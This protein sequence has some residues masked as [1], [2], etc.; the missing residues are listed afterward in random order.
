[1]HNLRPGK[2]DKLGIGYEALSAINPKLIY[3]YLPGY[4]SRGP[5]S[6]LKSFAP[7][8]SGWVGLLYEGGGEGNPPTRSVLGNEDY[9]NGFLG[10]VAVLMAVENRYRTG[11]GDYVECPQLHSSLFTTSEHFLDANKQVVYGLRMDG[12]QTGFN[13][14]DC[15][16][17]TSDGWICVCCR[18]D[19]RFAALAKGIGRED[20]LG[21][22]RF[23]TDRDRLAN[24]KVLREILTT[25]FA[26]LTSAEA[27]AQLDR[28][29]A[30]AEIVCETSWVQEALWQ[31]WAAKTDRVFE[32]KDSMYGH[33]REFG[34]F[35]RLS[36]TPGVR[37]GPAPR[38]GH[39]TREIL[40]EI[41]YSPAEIEG[42]IARKTAIQAERVTG[43]ID[44][45]RVSAARWSSTSATT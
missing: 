35:A 45:V 9:N 8:V 5:K 26:S 34:L 2:A 33:I 28:A 27:F 15:I 29:G 41:G 25:H 14:L 31:D 10:A 16:Y 17:R 44:Q 40:A 1:M 3:A 32:E 12:G 22:G 11:R 38:L 7:L 21:D 37:K 4:G 30:P 23:S 24:D 19:R 13:A 42:L 18:A 36:A 39:H 20:L 43:R 6:L